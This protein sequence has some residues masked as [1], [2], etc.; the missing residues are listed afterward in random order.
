MAKV[1]TINY[2]PREYFQTLHDSNKRWS[3]IVAHRRSGKTTATINHL[4]R[5]ALTKENSRY[6]YIAPTYKQAKAIAWDILKEFSRAIPRI[7]I[8][9]A[10]LRIDYPNG[11][12]IT[13]FGADN[14][15]SLRGLGLWGVVFDEYSQQPSN[16]FTEIIRPALADHNGYAIWIGTPKGKNEFYRLYENNKNNPDWLCLLLTVDNTGIIAQTELEDARKLMT[17]DEFRQEWYCSFEASIKGAYYAEEISNARK[18]NRIKFM[19]YDPALKVHT[20]WDLGIG[21]NLAIGFWQ[22]TINEVRMV[23]YWE[24]TEKEGIPQAISAIQAKGYVYGK[25]FAPHDIKATDQSTGKTRLETAKSLGIEFEVVPELGIDQGIHAA[26][27]MWPRVWINDVK[28]QSFLDYISQ[29]RREWDEK[30]GMF[31][32]VPFHDFTSHAGDMFRYA[33]LVEDK[34]VNENQTPINWRALNQYTDPN[35]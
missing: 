28:C 21:Q 29:Y 32:E 14:P 34:M 12:R 13:L 17:G 33:A 4:I 15:D 26:K 2:K 27:M 22:K 7:K 18:E 31:K 11:S 9:E 25:H 24:G 16:I 20:V 19:P 23:D 35:V 5:D 30:R 8:N 6:A 3:V 10:E 1:I